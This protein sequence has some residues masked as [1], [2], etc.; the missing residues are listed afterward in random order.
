[1]M[2]IDKIKIGDRF[3]H[4]MQL[5]YRDGVDSNGKTIHGTHYLKTLVE[6]TGFEANGHNAA[7]KAIE[8]I[9]ERNPPS[10]VN[11]QKQLQSAQMRGGFRLGIDQP[12]F[13]EVKNG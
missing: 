1:M 2:F 7:Y 3:I 5:P 4:T 11:S 6:I 10:W 9:E 8:I 12:E 13:S